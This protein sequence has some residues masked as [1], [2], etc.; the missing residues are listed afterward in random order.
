MVVDDIDII[1]SKLTNMEELKVSLKIII[2]L[3]RS[4]LSPSFTRIEREFVE[5]IE[6]APN[7]YEI[8]DWKRK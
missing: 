1:S 2:D 3:R 7:L 4:L 5:N 6:K 8:F